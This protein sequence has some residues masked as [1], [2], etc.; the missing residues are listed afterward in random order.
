MEAAEE[1]EFTLEN[2][3]SK[4]ARPAAWIGPLKRPI[5]TADHVGQSNVLHFGSD[6]WGIGSYK[7]YVEAGKK[8]IQCIEENDYGNI[9]PVACTRPQKRPTQA[10]G[11]GG[12]SFVQHFGSD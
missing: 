2:S 6:Q 8:E 10:A 7:R 12:P 1:D 4:N 11:N 3:I 9:G 5:Q